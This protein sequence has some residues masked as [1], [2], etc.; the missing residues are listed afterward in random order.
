M[1]KR[2]ITYAVT[3]AVLGLLAPV[4]WLVVRIASGALSG[5]S[6][7]TELGAHLALYVFMAMGGAISYGAVCG[8][9]GSAVD[10][11]AKLGELYTELGA[12]LQEA[13]QRLE[14]NVVTDPVTS[15]KNAR[16]FND[17]LPTECGRAAR[18][19][20]PLALIVLEIDQHKQ[21]V[22]EDPDW[23]DQALAHV[24]S[25]LNG[26]VRSTDIACR[27]GPDSFAIICPGA[28]NADARNVAERIRTAIAA[29]PAIIGSREHPLTA[30][31]GVAIYSNG[32]TAKD[33]YRAAD[34]ARQIARTSGRNRVS[35]SPSSGRMSIRV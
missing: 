10:R 26:Q 34:S 12:Q 17:W 15:L 20:K 16:F 4:S 5:D 14:E 23:A 11:N 7:G 1:Q 24:A 3:G 29:S 30:S 28:L 2:A 33:F 8:L 21:M 9:Y 6:V 18:D 25:V 22:Q 32:A 19:N 13:T 35:L 31:C 27:L